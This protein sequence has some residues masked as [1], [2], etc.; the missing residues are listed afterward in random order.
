M[1]LWSIRTPFLSPARRRGHRGASS[2]VQLRF[3]D[4][5]QEPRLL[6]ERTENHRGRTSQSTGE[7]LPLRKR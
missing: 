7:G 1:P 5:L 4:A 2:A 6:Q 3:G